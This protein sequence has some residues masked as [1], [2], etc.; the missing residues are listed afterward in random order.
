M[1]LD[2]SAVEKREKREKHVIPYSARVAL[3]CTYLLATSVFVGCGIVCVVYPS[4]APDNAGGR[5][6]TESS[7]AVC[8]RASRYADFSTARLAIGTPAREVEVLIRLDWV[9]ESS[10]S[11]T[12]LWASTVAASGTLNCTAEQLC[13]DVTLVQSGVKTAA[14]WR[15]ARFALHADLNDYSTT[16][17]LGLKGMMRLVRG[18]DYFLTTTHLCWAPHVPDAVSNAS[19]S[20][21]FRVE[22]AVRG[23]HLVEV[24]QTRSRCDGVA[25]SLLFPHGASVESRWLAL[26]DRYLYEHDEEDLGL[27]RDVVESG[28]VC[29]EKNITLFRSLMLYDAQC[30]HAECQRSPSVPYRRIAAQNTI[31]IELPHNT[32]N[33]TI[34]VQ[35]AIT[36]SRLPSL[37][38]SYSATWIAAAQLALVVLVAAVSFVRSSQKVVSPSFI[39]R[40]AFAR[41]I[42]DLREQVL[43]LAFHSLYEVMINALIGVL[44]LSARFAVILASWDLLVEDNLHRV[45]VSESVGCG[46]SLLHFLSRNTILRTDLNS[47]SPLT[48]LGGKKP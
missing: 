42:R 33:A 10:A 38:S 20:D 3:A 47:E 18:H 13:S 28:T 26:T 7:E 6:V 24:D 43:H 37:V 16:S 23:E 29:A 17:Q 41:C 12:I 9:V 1:S 31:T 2:Y 21:E 11:A 19:I 34:L 4:S 36:M 30:V 40:H 25:S 22:A 46:V 8:V 45:V 39:L 48:K 15:A 5:R 32:E 14:R 27:R 44:A 35:K